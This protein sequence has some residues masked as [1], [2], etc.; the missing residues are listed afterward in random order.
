V[1]NRWQRAARTGTTFA[2]LA[3]WLCAAGR[4]E[5]IDRVLAVVAGDV[6]MQSDVTLARELGTA[7]GLLPND[8]DDVLRQLIDRALVLAEVDRYAPPEP[9]E[10]AVESALERLKSRVPSPTVDDV[11]W[12]TGVSEA[13]LRGIL[14]QNLRISAYVDQRFAVPAPSDRELERFYE[15]RR[16]QFTRAG[17]VAPLDVVRDEVARELANDRRRTLVRDW[18]VGLRRRAGPIVLPPA[19]GD[20]VPQ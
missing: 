19:S 5:V 14:R 16:E 8:E 17:A 20:R 13:H 15:E 2:T 4:A 10:A 11:L 7:A 9:R 1:Q 3:L 12:K 6:I 18:I